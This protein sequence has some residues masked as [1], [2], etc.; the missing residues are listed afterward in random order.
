MQAPLELLYALLMLLLEEMN[1][2]HDDVRVGPLLIVSVQLLCEE[3]FDQLFCKLMPIV[4]VVGEN[5]IQRRPSALPYT[6][7]V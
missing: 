1:F 2:A 7:A 6:L 4:A 5:Q 3:L